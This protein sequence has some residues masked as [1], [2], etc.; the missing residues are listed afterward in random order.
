LHLSSFALLSVPQLFRHWRWRPDAVVGVEPTLFCAP[1][2]LVA[3]RLF[4][5]ASVLHI[6]DF[7]L[8]AMLGLGM[9]KKVAMGR[10]ANLGTGIERWLMRR[11]DAVST[12][13]YSMVEHVVGKLGPVPRPARQPPGPSHLP[14]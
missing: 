9:G 2:T 13:S 4:G 7:E 14:G 11:F 3:A 12:I 5:A 1:A 8:N 6:Q 10:L